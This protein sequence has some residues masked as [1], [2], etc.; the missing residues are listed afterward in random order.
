MNHANPDPQR[1]AQAQSPQPSAKGGAP[2]A[3][4][5]CRVY[6]WNH[7]SITL[8]APQRPGVY[9]LF[10]ALWI[11]IGEADDI[12]A[13]LLGHL[14]GDNPCIAHYQPSGFAF[15]LVDEEGRAERRDEIAALLEPLCN[16][17]SFV[18]KRNGVAKPND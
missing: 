4:R 16:G 13:R 7:E 18:H 6:K 12:R 11:Y 8:H 5:G 2:F 9:G 3:E 14:A 17:N 1:A 15:E 10:N